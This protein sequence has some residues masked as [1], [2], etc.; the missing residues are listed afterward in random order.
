M[1]K[2]FEKLKQEKTTL[3]G[4]VNNLYSQARELNKSTRINSKGTKKNIKRRK[5]KSK[6]D[7]K[8]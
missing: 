1:E 2:Y 8:R 6:K 5:P 3:E 7:K 4:I